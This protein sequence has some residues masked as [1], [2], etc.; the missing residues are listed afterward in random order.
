MDYIEI[1]KAK[2]HNLK[3]VSLK[4]PRNN[5]VVI[6]GPSGS[7]KSSLAFDTLYAEGQR[8]YIES[9]SSYARQFLGQMDPPDVESIS[10]LSPAIAIDQKSTS[11]N[12]RSTVGTVTEIY[13][14]LRVLYA[15]I[16]TAYCPDSGEKLE[17][18]SADQITQ[19]LLDYPNKSKIFIFAPIIKHAKGEHKEMFQKLLA[20]GYTKARVNKEL[21]PIEEITLTKNKKASIDLLIDRLVMK[22]GVESRLNDS[23]EQAL[24]MGDGQMIALV[25]EQEL[26]FSE[27]FYSAATD[28]YYPS[29]EPRLFSFNSPIGACQ[30]CNGLGLKKDFI[31]KKFILDDNLSLNEGALIPFTKSSF[32]F[33]MFKCMA[34]TE[35]INLDTPFKKLKAQHKDL[36][37]NGSGEKKYLFS[38][39]SDR[40]KF[41]FRRNWS[42]VNAWLQKKY[43]NTGSEKVRN[44]LESLMAIESCRDCEGTRLNPFAS[45]VKIKNKPIHNLTHLSIMEIF[46][47]LNSWKFTG[48][49]K[50]I[51]D[52]LLKEIKSRLKFLLDVGLNY[53]NLNRTA[54]TLSGGESQRIRLATQIGSALTGVLYVLDEPSIG[55]HQRD[56]QKLIK[57]L[58]ELRDLNNSVIVVEHDEETMQE[59]D[60]IIDM[61]PGAGIHGGEVVVVGPM[62]KIIKNKKSLTGQFLSGRDQIE[63]ALPRKVGKHELK[64]MNFSCHNVQKLNAVI[65]LGG[66][67]GISGVSGSGKSTFVHQGIV[68][69]I[70]NTL[71]K[72]SEHPIHYKA[73][74][75]VDEIQSIIELDQTPIGRTPKS[76]P[77]TY[78]KLFDEIRTLFS[79]TKDSKMKGYK[80]GRFSFNVKGGRCESCEGNGMVKVEMNFLP[81]VFITCSECKGRRY[82]SETLK[83]TY[84]GQN[85]ADVLQ[86]SIEEARDFFENHPK[87]NRILS[88]L[89]D[90]GLGYM[91]LGQSATTLSGGEAQRLKLSRELSKRTKG[92]TLYVLDEPTTGLHFNDI[93]IL[94]KAIKRLI[95]NNNTVLVIEH[96][97]DVLKCA[98]FIIDMGPEG[99]KFG[100]QIVSSGSPEEVAKDKNS[101]T[102]KYLKKAL[103]VGKTNGLLQ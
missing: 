83:V 102:G 79:Q 11:R 22:D 34:K 71:D 5:L 25:D 75:G 62:D 69:A 55:L 81:D 38:F 33:H 72:K 88:T 66:L 64:L 94:I 73:I 28:N 21:M 41:E 84:R 20:Q 50:I 59:A 82:N 3:N 70:K 63:Y 57:T 61:G 89:F 93:K 2:V 8:R 95:E 96:N 97:L 78:T 92:H 30:G 35:K 36:I 14:Y 101:V 29:L 87:I 7:G 27:S 91:K 45:S 90:V 9:L 56:N 10:G 52:K 24:K 43:A 31:E 99:G 39:I 74:T 68:P 53:L 23:I 77:A 58:K 49:E 65:P 17:Q 48:S 13:D 98:D 44:S 86:M 80:P 47:Q 37:L 54:S 18:K 26:F 67:V 100:G 51:S 103:K 19:S 85:V 4:I 12:P 32:L 46:E 76:N 60:Y 16:G 6:T 40:S 42:G 15:R 1:Q